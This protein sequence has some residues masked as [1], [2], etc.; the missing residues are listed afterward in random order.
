MTES[1]M[2]RESKSRAIADREEDRAGEEQTMEELTLRGEETADQ[3][4]AEDDKLQS[5]HSACK[6]LTDHLEERT[7]ARK[8]VV[9]SLSKSKAVLQ[10]ASLEE[11]S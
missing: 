2:V 8:A 10:G 7:T 4:R 6:Q 5:L 1:T 3:I 9:E 11:A